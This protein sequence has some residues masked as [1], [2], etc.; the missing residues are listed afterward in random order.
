[1]E[2]IAQNTLSRDD[3]AARIALNVQPDQWIEVVIAIG[4]RGDKAVVP[5]RFHGGET[6]NTRRPIA[7][8]IFEGAF[9]AAS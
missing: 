5:E 1:V 9:P 4:R 8:A 7:E 2:R 3:E 6:P